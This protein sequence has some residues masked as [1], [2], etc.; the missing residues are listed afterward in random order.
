[1]NT[2]KSPLFYFSILGTLLFSML[3]VFAY[4][5]GIFKHSFVF[6]ITLLTLSLVSVMV[7]YVDILANRLFIRSRML[8]TIEYLISIICG[9]WFIFMFWHN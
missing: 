1:M 2:F 3:Y 7:L 8:R 4:V 6:G 5:A 9:I